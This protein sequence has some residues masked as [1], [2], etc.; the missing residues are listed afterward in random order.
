MFK[1]SFYLLLG[2]LL[3]SCNTRKA[4]VNRL[5]IIDTTPT[6][7]TTGL[8]DMTQ[9]DAMNAAA[10]NYGFHYSHVGG[11]VNPKRLQD[12]IRIINDS[13]YGK[14][15]KKHGNRWLTNF[16]SQVDLIRVI[17]SQTKALLA[18]NAEIYKMNSELKSQGIEIS[19]EILPNIETHTITVNAYRWEK[20]D[21]Q[22]YKA[23]YYKV[24]ID[25]RK[26]NAITLL[27]I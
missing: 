5:I 20:I 25:P 1:P 24:L 21:A 4:G 7:L 16:F 18:C 19:F 2:F 11:C 6:A 22:F 14:L 8:P 23:V 15:T 27:P 10:K 12:S 26:S 17:Q 3:F 13:I 9:I